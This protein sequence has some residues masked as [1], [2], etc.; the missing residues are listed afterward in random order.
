MKEQLSANNVMKVNYILKKY[1]SNKLVLI[2]NSKT[3]RITMQ[4]H[5]TVKFSKS[6]FQTVDKKVQ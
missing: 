3:T 1:D 6:T 2:Q 4:L 5:W